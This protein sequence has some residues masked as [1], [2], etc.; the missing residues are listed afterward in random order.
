MGA[1]WNNN[2]GIIN[3]EPVILGL[4]MLFS[5]TALDIL[6][7]LLHSQLYMQGDCS[8]TA[9]VKGVPKSVKGVPKSNNLIDP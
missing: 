8:K 3:R 1:C 9:N 2:N 7:F 5:S 4:G 6:L